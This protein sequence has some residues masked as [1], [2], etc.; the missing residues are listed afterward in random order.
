MNEYHS[1]KGRMIVAGLIF[2]MLLMFTA[3]VF[4]FGTGSG[5]FKPRHF[6]AR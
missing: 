5:F 6:E 1:L 2:A 4:T 3:F